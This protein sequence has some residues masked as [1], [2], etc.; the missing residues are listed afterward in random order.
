MK[1]KEYEPAPQQVSEDAAASLFQ[2]FHGHRTAEVCA[3]LTSLQEAEPELWDVP[4]Q[5]SWEECV[6]G[7]RQGLTPRNKTAFICFSSVHYEWP[8]QSIDK[9]QLLKPHSSRWLR[10]LVNFLQFNFQI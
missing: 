5:M 6:A 8:F 1:K 3:E 7:R 9:I 10:N 4:E 2:G